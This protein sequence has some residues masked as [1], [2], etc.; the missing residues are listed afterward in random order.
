MVDLGLRGNPPEGK[1]TGGVDG[2][3]R[4]GKSTNPERVDGGKDDRMAALALRDET[5]EHVQMCM[6]MALLFSVLIFPIILP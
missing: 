2:F 1:V 6:F 4:M 3:P 5:V